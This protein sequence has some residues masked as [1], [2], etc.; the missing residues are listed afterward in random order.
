MKCSIGFSTT[1]SIASKIIRLFIKS[2]MT[3]CYISFYDEFLKIPIIFHADYTGVVMENRAIFQK[4]NII[5][6]EF[7]FESDLVLRSIQKNSKYL[8]LK[9]DFPVL[10][11]WALAIA[12]QRWVEKKIERPF[13]DPEALW[14]VD[15]ALK[16]T[17]DTN[18]TSLPLGRY[19]PSTLFEWCEKNYEGR[20][21]LK[22]LP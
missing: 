15:F 10:K 3:H 17:N 9:Y 18:E 13:E 20:G 7:E 5:I 22:K 21:W 11:D 2:R 16:V 19:L 4:H 8:G 6:Q 12:F 14:C 1:N